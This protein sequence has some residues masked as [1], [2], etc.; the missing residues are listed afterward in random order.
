MSS[1]WRSVSRFLLRIWII[2][3]C[4]MSFRFFLRVSIVSVSRVRPSASKAFDGLKNSIAVWSSWVSDTVSSSRPFCSRS[5]AAAARTRFTYSPRF[6][7]ISSIVISAATVRSAST[8]LPSTSSFSISGCMVRWPSVCAAA[9]I[10][11]AS[12]LHAHVELARHVDAH[13]VL[14]DERALAAARHLEAQRVHVHRDDLVDDRQHE[15]AAVHHH[16]LAAE[17]GAHE[18]PLLGRAQ[19]QPV[20]Q[21]DHDRDD[22]RDADQGEDELSELGSSHDATPLLMPLN[23]LRGLSQGDFGGQ[24][25]HARGAVEAVAAAAVLQDVL[26]VLGRGDRP[27]VAQH[28]DVRVHAARRLG[29]RIDQRHAVLQLQ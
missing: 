28:Q 6:S 9:A 15:R 18:R 5:A 16:L 4:S 21:P 12:A 27:A 3:S 11:S 13:A 26:R 25:L 22:D 29:P 14:G 10:A 2:V 8:N 19:V 20:E 1:A 24:A 7:C 23:F 17:A